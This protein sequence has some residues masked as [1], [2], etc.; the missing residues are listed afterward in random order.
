MCQIRQIVLK[1]HLLPVWHKSHLFWLKP[2]LEASVFDVWVQII[3]YTLML[4]MR[5]SRYSLLSQWYRAPVNKLNP[6]ASICMLMSSCLGWRFTYLMRCEFY[7]LLNTLGSCQ[8]VNHLASFP[9]LLVVQSWTSAAQSWSP[10]LPKND[11]ISWCYNSTNS[12]LRQ[13]AEGTQSI[14]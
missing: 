11:Y 12:L 6:A 8:W 13:Q 7:S 3:L 10:D 14:A 9:S 5:M 1:V 2:N 4:I